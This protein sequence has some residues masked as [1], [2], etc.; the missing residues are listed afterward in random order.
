MTRL[1]FKVRVSPGSETPARR[2]RMQIESRNDSYVKNGEK[3]EK[4]VQNKSTN[5]RKC[6]KCETH[7]GKELF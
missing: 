2:Y 1:V 4:R 7:G 3:Y 6:G 5:I